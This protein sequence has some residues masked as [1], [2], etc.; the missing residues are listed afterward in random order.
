MA[1]GNLFLGTAAGKVGSVVLS[2]KNGVQLSRAYLATKRNPRTVAQAASRAIFK[3]A[4]CAYSQL[5]DICRFSWQGH[6]ADG[7]HQ[8]FM[9]ANTAMLRARV[10]DALDA[11]GSAVLEC[12]VGNFNLYGEFVGLLNPWVVSDGSLPSLGAV[13]LSDLMIPASWDEEDLDYSAFNGAL[14]LRSGDSVYFVGIL[15]QV[16]SVVMARVVI[17]R[18]V[19][20]VDEGLI[21]LSRDFEWINTG[22]GSYNLPEVNSLTGGMSWRPSVPDGYYLA[23]GFALAVREVPGSGVLC[24]S[25]VMAVAGMPAG[26]VKPFGLAVDSFMESGDAVGSAWLDNG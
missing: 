4:S 11:G 13:L 10:Q 15:A 1:R 22:P 18:L 20:P 26:A 21:P 12:A 2:V 3:T 7:C 5:I 23:G 24:S 25:E 16:G 8:R 6:N 19:I 9:R 14:G 17:G